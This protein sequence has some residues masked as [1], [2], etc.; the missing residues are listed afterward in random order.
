MERVITFA[1]LGDS[2]ASGVGDADVN[3]IT[4]GWAYYLT[5]SFQDPIVYANL[6]RPGAKSLEVLE[7][8]LPSALLYKPDIAAVIVGG[9]DV[10]RNG[11]SPSKLHENLQ[12]TISK[13]RALG[14]HVILLQLHDPTK[15]VPLPGLLARVLRRRINAVNRVTQSLAHEFGADVLQTRRINNIYD[16]KVWHVD[17]MHPSKFGHQLLAKHFR[18]ILLLKDW[19]IAPIQIEPVKEISK[20]QSVKWMLRNGTPWF[21][22][23]SVDLFPA[24]ILLMLAELLRPL[25][26]RGESDLT[27]L[28]F[29]DFQ[30]QSISDLQEVYEERVS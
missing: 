15:I 7:V 21:L 29:A 27:N 5:Q 19:N 17:R 11:F 28:Y 20:V 14:T 24:A 3:G 4:R 2:A 8:Q 22:K 18:D 25:A 1:V 12:L 30:P 23:R 16:R 26:K 6:S 10:L 9:N 13:L